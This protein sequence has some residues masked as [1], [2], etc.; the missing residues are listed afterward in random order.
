MSLTFDVAMT[1]VLNIFSLSGFDTL[2]GLVDLL[3]RHF[4]LIM[5]E[6]NMYLSLVSFNAGMLKVKA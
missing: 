1:S 2:G 3:L 6:E 4:D 5:K